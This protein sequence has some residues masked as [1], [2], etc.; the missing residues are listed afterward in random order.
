MR[1]AWLSVSGRACSLA[2][3]G[4]LLLS[5][6]V[7]GAAPLVV[8]W[9]APACAEESAFRA[10]VHD[11][12][13]REPEAALEQELK[14]SVTIREEP[15]KSQFSLLIRMNAGARQL[16][17]PSCEEAVAAAAT[18]VALSIDPNV[19][20]PSEPAPAAEPARPAEPPKLDPP[21]A[22]QAK[23]KAL[24]PRPERYVAAFGGAS[25]GEVP[26]ISPLVGAAFG[27]RFRR[28][29][30]AADAFW[31]APQ[32]QLLIGTSKG[33]SVGVW[34][35]GLSACYLLR[36]PAL[37]LSG[38]LGVQAGAWHSRGEGVTDPTEQTDGWLAGLARLGA[39]V[40][41]TSTW[42]LY[43]AGDALVPARRPWFAVAQL[44]RIFRPE[45]VG[46]RLSAGLELSF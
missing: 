36:Q 22:P 39:S 31:I 11:A 40:P 18:L 28:F 19:A 5:A 46:E 44:G 38:C 6:Q 45:A 34:G 3:A 41:V 17:L 33:G 14:V 1:G 7:A 9:Q 20:V 23:P 37:R 13:Q 30:L 21:P 8:S 24:A 12:L 2:G 16:Q 32:T 42:G 43:L 26:A 4:S 29:A 15:E 10:R 25:F 35:A 27:W